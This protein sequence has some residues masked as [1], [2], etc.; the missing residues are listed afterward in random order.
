MPRLQPPYR[1]DFETETS[2]AIY[3]LQASWL[4]FLTTIL[5]LLLLACFLIFLLR[6]CVLWDRE[7]ARDGFI[8]GVP[9][10]EKL[11]RRC[12]ERGRRICK[13][14]GVWDV[15]VR[16]GPP[17][18]DSETGVDEKPKGK[19]L[20]FLPVA[21]VI[22]PA[23]TTADAKGKGKARQRTRSHSSHINSSLRTSEDRGTYSMIYA[24]GMTGAMAGRRASVASEGGSYAGP[25]H[26]RASADWVERDGEE[27]V[28][29]YGAGPWI[30]RV[31]NLSETRSGGVM[32][33]RREETVG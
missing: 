18:R 10:E 9:R 26:R 6:L 3:L 22:P 30:R 14:R 24:A 28:R 13:E 17:A 5:A 25:S 16:G 11:L 29:F 33:G 7:L 12:E 2:L 15:G 20:R 8:G 31:R 4:A 32:E 27:P 1:P 23:P 19:K 21:E